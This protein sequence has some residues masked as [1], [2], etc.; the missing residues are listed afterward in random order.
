MA[1]KAR[2]DVVLSKYKYYCYGAVV[3][4]AL[5]MAGLL[6]SGRGWVHGIAVSLLP[7]VVAQVAIDHFSERRAHIYSDRLSTN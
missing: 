7:V 3:L 1:E 2:I 6:L 5:A 4:A